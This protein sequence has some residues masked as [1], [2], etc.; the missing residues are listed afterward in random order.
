[1]STQDTA[2][3][4]TG[5]SGR[6]NSWKTKTPETKPAE[7]K[8][9]KPAEINAT[10]TKTPEIKS[11]KLAEIKKTETKTPELKTLK[12]T[13]TKMADKKVPEMKTT[14]LGKPAG[15]KPVSS[16]FSSFRSHCSVSTVVHQSQLS[17]F[18]GFL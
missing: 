9:M 7:T 4:N 5:V 2:G 6:I 10:E 3:L 17:A 1:M 12:P 15:G 16:F 11:T 8:S 13:D 18:V 14:A